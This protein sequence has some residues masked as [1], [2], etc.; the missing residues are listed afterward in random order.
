MEGTLTVADIAYTLKCTS[1]KRQVIYIE[2]IFENT[3]PI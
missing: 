2:G 1:N 3:E